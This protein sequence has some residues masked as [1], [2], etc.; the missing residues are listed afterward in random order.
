MKIQ[1]HLKNNKV[2][3]WNTGGVSADVCEKDG[4][5]LDKKVLEI[6]DEDWDKIQQGYVPV[7]IND[8]FSVQ[9]SA[10]LI[11]EETKKK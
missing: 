9:K 3:A 11:Q 2:L 6:S 7:V 4:I 8:V 10:I 5:L 1:L